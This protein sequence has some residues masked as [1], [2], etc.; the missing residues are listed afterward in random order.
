MEYYLVEAFTNYDLNEFVSKKLD[1][2]WKLYGYPFSGDN[3]LYQAMI[4]D[5]SPSEPR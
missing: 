5:Y 4:R 3:K 2:G 1:K